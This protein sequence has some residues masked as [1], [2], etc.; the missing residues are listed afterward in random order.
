MATTDGQG[1]SRA[2]HVKITLVA[3]LICLVGAAL[4]FKLAASNVEAP[5]ID[6]NEVVEQA[7][8]FMGGELEHHF[9]K[10]GP[11]TMYVLAALYRA[12]AAIRGLSALDY[13][14]RVFFEGAEHYLIARGLAV[15]SLVVVAWLGF[16]S[17][18]RHFG[19]APALFVCCLLGLPLADVLYSG[20]RIDVIQAAFQALTLLALAEVIASPRRRYWLMA[21]A[22]AGLGIATKP[23]PGLL[24]LPCFALASWF[25]AAK[26]SAGKTRTPLS[27]L[28]AAA[29]Q[30]GLWLAAIVCIGFTILAD[31]AVLDIREFVASQRDAIALHSGEREVRLRQN[32]PGALR[33]LGLPFLSLAGLA[34]IIGIVRRDA[35]SL[36]V[37]L[38]VFVYL[39]AFWGRGARNYFMVA[40]ALAACLLMGYAFASLYHRP[41]Q[42]RTRR[43][44]ALCWLPVIAL[45]VL[46]PVKHLWP[47]LQ[48]S[49]SLQARAWVHEHIPSG[50][51]IFHV[52]PRP[53]SP[54]LVGTNEKQQG[55]WG[56]H[57]EYGRHKYKFLKQAFRK[58]FSDYKASGKPLYPLAVYD[59][60]PLPRS[61]GVPR[62]ISDS[63]LRNAQAEGQR[64]IVVSGFRQSNVMDLG[65]R[66]FGDAHL[67]ATFKGIAIFKVPQKEPDAATLPAAAP[68]A[69]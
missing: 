18:R 27:R 14:S 25:V 12:V 37:T 35:R 64:Y 30:P 10:Y 23:L 4:R 45:L 24:V 34:A 51:P 47:R 62:T 56:D 68:S 58:A 46:T 53:G 2:S 69:P 60:K 57:F 28:G 11:L 13:A 17:F 21:G 54:L 31:P 26:D 20:V 5:Y 15:V 49:S 43:W 67:E 36:L 16:A 59:G 29:T 44:L 3:L 1:H 38:F 48:L 61:K 9:M 39:A 6:E 55:R 40:P 42:E 22:C 7:V 8:A 63:L 19:P 32:V 33:A 66:W 50:T 41:W 65:Y 52:G